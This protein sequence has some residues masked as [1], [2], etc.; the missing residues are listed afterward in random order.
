[1]R[2]W[3]IK[4]CMLLGEKVRKRRTKNE[5]EQVGL[6]NNSVLYFKEN[7]GCLKLIGVSYIIY[8]LYK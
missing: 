1:M 6:L 4:R 2:S 8:K 7:S 3:T 5:V